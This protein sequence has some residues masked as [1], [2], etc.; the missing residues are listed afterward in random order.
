METQTLRQFQDYQEGKFVKHFVYREPEFVAFVLSFDAGQRLPVHK[1]P[2]TK[3]HL[4]VLEGSGT[5]TADGAE[6]EVKEGETVVLS[7]DADFS[8]SSS[9]D[10]RSSLYVMLI[11]APPAV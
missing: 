2:G 8:Y 11:Q 6:T 7:G 4:L 10:G 3:L 9:A 5:V 1:H